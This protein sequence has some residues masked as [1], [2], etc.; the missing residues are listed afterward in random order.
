VP[1]SQDNLVLR[2]ARAFHAATGIAGGARFVLRKRIPAGGGLGGGS[3]DAASAL[4]ILQAIHGR[5][6]AEPQLRALAATLGADVPFFLKAGTQLG[7]GIGDQLT[8]LPDFQRLELLLILPPFGTS[9]AAVYKNC[10]AE[11][12]MATEACRNPTSK[13]P[14]PKALA[15]PDDLV[16][17]LEA[18]AFALHHELRELWAVVARVDAGVRMSGS[19][20][21][22]FLARTFTRAVELDLAQ[23]QL[24]HLQDHGVVLLRTRSQPQATPL[25]V[26][27]AE[28]PRRA[29]VPRARPRVVHGFRGASATSEGWD[30]IW[31]KAQEPPNHA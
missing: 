30:K 6:L 5:P 4:L 18:P 1:D 11:L 10:A 25:A 19:G 3:S 26:S 31:A 7:A 12:T 28:L 29:A 17:D 21:T 9:T 27:E 14:V 13:V 22:L 15:V 23:R 24:A 2:A 20:S 8:P 16:N